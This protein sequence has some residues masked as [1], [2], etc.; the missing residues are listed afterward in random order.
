MAHHVGV[1]A[2]LVDAGTVIQVGVIVAGQL[3]W[4]AADGNL[5]RRAVADYL[6]THPD[7]LSLLGLAITFERSDWGGMLSFSVTTT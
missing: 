5:F 3:C 4:L 1:I 2:H 6:A 7:A